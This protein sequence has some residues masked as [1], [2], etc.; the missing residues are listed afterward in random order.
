MDVGQLDVRGFVRT[1]RGLF[2]DDLVCLRELVQNALEAVHQARLAGLEQALIDV[3]IGQS[4]STLTVIDN[5]IGMTAEE[6][7]SKLT[8]LFRTGWPADTGQTLGIGQ[9]GF[10]FYSVFLAGDEVTVSSRSRERPGEAHQLAIS[11]ADGACRLQPVNPA[12]VPLGTTITVP[13]RHELAPLASAEAVAEQLAKTFLYT[14]YRVTVDGRPA[15]IPDRDGWLEELRAAGRRHD[16]GPRFAERYGWSSEPLATMPLTPPLRGWLVACPEGVLAPPVEVFRRGIAVTRTELIPEPLNHFLCGLVDADEVG[17]RPD[18]QSLLANEA[19]RALKEELGR[20]SFTWLT[21]L[22]QSAPQT[23][24]ALLSAHRGALLGALSHHRELRRG[25]GAAWPVS[26]FRSRERR[27]L[28]EVVGPTGRVVWIG[29]PLREQVFA[30]RAFHLGQ[31]PVVLGEAEE[32]RLVERLCED[33]ELELVAA[34][35][36]YL[37]EMRQRLATPGR[38]ERV[39]GTVLPQ[40]YE[41]LTCHDEDQ[42]FPLKVVVSAAHDLGEPPNEPVLRKLWQLF[43]AASA[44]TVVVLNAEHPVIAE[45]GRGSGPPSERETRF[46]RVLFLLARAACGVRI[47]VE[48]A[49]AVYELLAAHLQ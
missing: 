48:E 32:R 10:G 38:A 16:T 7:T 47:S 27:P 29:D 34:S 5:G 24:R 20:Q 21:S 35:R 49:G 3:R 26:V 22:Q 40:G 37:D 19:S 36:A 23:F 28:A 42:R 30:D 31:S 17:L 1:M 4:P 13:L 11:A 8:V 18:R 46:A 33:L 41:V 9:F 15:G 14:A 44:A 6:L 12:K 39:V 45:F 43:Q 25:V 2:D